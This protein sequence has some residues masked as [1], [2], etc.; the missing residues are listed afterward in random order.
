MSQDDAAAMRETLANIFGR[1]DELDDADLLRALGKALDGASK[2][3]KRSRTLVEVVVLTA[4]VDHLGFDACQRAMDAH[5]HE[6]E[7]AAQQQG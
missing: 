6:L 5:R 7:A 3:D 4:I 2:L 1:F